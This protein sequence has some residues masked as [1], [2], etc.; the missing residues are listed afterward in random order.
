MWLGLV[1]LGHRGAWGSTDGGGA[2][3]GW[4]MVQ[5]AGAGG[6]SQES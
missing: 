5:A 4:C 1:A 2:G 6:G 3:G